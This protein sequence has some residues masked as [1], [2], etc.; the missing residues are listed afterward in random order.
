MERKALIKVRMDSL[1]FKIKVKATLVIK[2]LKECQ[3]KNIKV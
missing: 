2:Y 1:I 3:I